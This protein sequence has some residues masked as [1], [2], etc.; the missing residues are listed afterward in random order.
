MNTNICESNQSV[1]SLL[2]LKIHSFY[3]NRGIYQQNVKYVL[4]PNKTMQNG[5]LNLPTE[6]VFQSSKLE[7]RGRTPNFRLSS[8]LHNL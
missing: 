3:K 2:R 7:N 4:F 6:H 5:K 8:T 1:L